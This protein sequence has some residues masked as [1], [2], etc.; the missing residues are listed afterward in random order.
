MDNNPMITEVLL[1]AIDPNLLIWGSVAAAVLLLVVGIVCAVQ[2]VNLGKT[3]EDANT[4]IAAM[5]A[6]MP[7]QQLVTQVAATSHALAKT[8]QIHQKVVHAL[9][10]R[11]GQRV[12]EEVDKGLVPLKEQVSLSFE[13]IS[14]A[15]TRTVGSLSE[16]HND[17]DHALLTLNENGHFSEWIGTLRDGVSP[18]QTTAA[19]I[20]DHYTTSRNILQTT[21]DVLAKWAGHWESI[22]KCFLDIEMIVAE[23]NANDVT[24]FANIENRLVAH[25]EHVS[26]TSAELLDNL[27]ELKSSTTKMTG[28]QEHL[29]RTMN[30]TVQQVEDL[31][32]ESAKVQSGFASN[33]AH[34]NEFQDGFR[35]WQVTVQRRIDGF[36]ESLAATLSEVGQRLRE[37]DEEFRRTVSNS[38]KL[39]E[40]AEQRSHQSTSQ[41]TA[42]VSAVQASWQSSLDHQQQ[43]LAEQ[44][45]VWGHMHK[46]LQNLP[47]RGIQVTQLV[48][49]IVQALLLGICA[50]ALFR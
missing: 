2:L 48:I 28:A 25:F 43:V 47:S 19:A 7:D 44:K 20:E 36:N 50:Y 46:S 3:L 34:F 38:T 27:A 6:N 5:Q 45:Q 26:H 1:A 24:Q 13:G 33:A 15:L 12:A 23:R 14:Q 37:M 17:L 49:I 11:M 32:E 31:I 10:D 29:D 16:S 35:K 40:R 41:M 39:M 8:L 18:L 21:S 42:A 22:E 4:R 30:R 9:P